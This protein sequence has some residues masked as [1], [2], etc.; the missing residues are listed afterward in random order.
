M[1]LS[2][3]IYKPIALFLICLMLVGSVPMMAFAA[4]DNPFASFGLPVVSIYTDDPHVTITKE[5]QAPAT[6]SMYDT[7]E[8]KEIRD[9]QITI[10]GRGNST[11]NAPK[12]PYQIKFDSKTDVMG[13]G[14][15][16]KWILLASHF[17]QSL[18]KTQ[19]ATV[20]GESLRL[21]FVPEMRY[22]DLYLNG[23]Y[24]GNYII[25]EKVEMGSGR[26]PE[27]ENGY[28]LEVDNRLDETHWFITNND[29]HFTLKEPEFDAITPDMPEEEKQLIL[30]TVRGI[31]THIQ[32]IEDLM[33]AHDSSCF[34][35][36]NLD[37]FVDWY[38]I[39]ELFKN[40]DSCFFSS[41]YM[42]LEEDGKIVMGPLWDFDQSLGGAEY[43]V[44]KNPEGW[45]TSGSRWYKELRQIPLFENALKERWKEL[46]EEGRLDFLY[47]VIQETEPVIAASSAENYKK[48]PLRVFKDLSGSPKSSYTM[49]VDYLKEFYSR[50]LVWMD[51]KLN[52]AP[53]AVRNTE[54][55]LKGLP[56]ALV[57][58]SEGYLNTIAA[59]LNNLSPQQRERLDTS[60]LQ[61]YQATMEQYGRLD[62][63]K[64]IKSVTS[65]VYYAHVNKPFTISCTVSPDVTALQLRNENNGTIGYGIV[66]K[67]VDADGNLVWTFD[68]ALGTAGNNR[69]LKVVATGDSEYPAQTID[70]TIL[71]LSQQVPDKTALKNLIVQAEEIDTQPYA[72]AAVAVFEYVLSAAEVVAQNRKALQ[73]EIDQAAQALDDALQNMLANV[74][75]AMVLSAAIEG[76]TAVANSTAVLTVTATSNADA[77]KIV[78]DL[79]NTLP[80]TSKDM[81]PNGNGKLIGTLQFFV[82]TEVGKREL[83]LYCGESE[84]TLQDSGIRLPLLVLPSDPSQPQIIDVCSDTSSAQKDELFSIIVLTTPSVEKIKMTNELDHGVGLSLQNVTIKDNVKKWVYHISVGTAGNREFTFHC[85]GKN[86]VFSPN[87]RKMAMVITPKA[88]DAQVLTALPSRPSVM[89]NT[90]FT[91][92]VTTT[93]AVER[94]NFFNELDKAIGASLLSCVIEKNTKKWTY[95]MAIATPGDRTITAVCSPGLSNTKTFDISITQ[96]VPN[97]VSVA[98]TVSQAKTNQPFDV[99]IVTAPSITRI[100]IVNEQGGKIGILLLESSS[101]AD[102]TTRWVYRMQV[103]TAGS[104]TF[105]VHNIESGGSLSKDSKSFDIRIDK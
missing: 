67:K 75:P 71:P 45:Y 36:L 96:S 77:F 25:C 78:D 43:S 24:Q 2:K 87:I 90:D 49:Q 1:K 5:D 53:D 84:Q 102:G 15:S 66:Q 16:K 95:Q 14:K 59:A 21:G 80:I 64:G 13:M 100:A 92:T 50:R 6:I 72:P 60:L 65:D 68:C 62:T 22:V 85:A 34:D 63:S 33:Y 10:K 4:S 9:A 76:E 8:K 42:Y 74:S 30:D 52:S 88:E 20:F 3:R 29:I 73:T 103:G 48:W 57:P 94:V 69:V 54:S 79:G 31:Q 35:Y 93:M 46:R 7:G 105:F 82:G 17:D 37:T 47:D 101:L 91:V 39:N 61:Q 26:V 58:Q 41:C 11:W 70:F 55:L 28:L 38:I 98:A 32:M 104:R 19:L 51:S 27:V 86:G 12:K 83:S 97:F 89:Q 40:T 56:K 81:Q 23:A 99:V 18:L 44:L